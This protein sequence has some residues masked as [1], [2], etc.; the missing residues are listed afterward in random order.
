MWHKHHHYNCRCDK[1]TYY[2]YHVGGAAVALARGR[3]SGHRRVRTYNVKL[4]KSS[5]SGHVR[6]RFRVSYHPTE[7]SVRTTDIAL[8]QNYEGASV[9]K[10]WSCW[11]AI[12]SWRFP[13]PAARTKCPESCD[14]HWALRND[15]CVADKATHTWSKGSASECWRFRG[16][17]VLLHRRWSGSARHH[18]QS[19]LGLVSC[20]QRSTAEGIWPL[21]W[22]ERSTT[23][24]LEGGRFW[25]GRINHTNCED[26][27]SWRLN[28]ECPAP[29]V[30]GLWWLIACPHTWESAH[31][32]PALTQRN[33]RRDCRV[34]RCTQCCKFG[35]DLIHCVHT[36]QR[37]EWQTDSVL[38]NTGWTGGKRHGKGDKAICVD[39]GELNQ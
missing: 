1:F 11:E 24:W 17:R 4:C 22:S 21:R 33:I 29:F 9:F 31:L 20:D 35:H 6:P 18:T 19:A 14:G 10:L 23:R 15:A 2:T 26:D 13:G 28:T 8:R 7:L 37:S 25:A 16:K 34:T 39:K 38:G 12:S 27:T 3:V 32:P 30:Q 5:F 36:Y